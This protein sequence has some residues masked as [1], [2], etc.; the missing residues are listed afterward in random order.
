MDVRFL[1]DNPERDYPKV[2]AV[3]GLKLRKTI[4][5]ADYPSGMSQGYMVEGPITRDGITFDV[6]AAV[7]TPAC[8]MG[9]ILS[10][11]ADA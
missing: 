2:E 4:G 3:T 10:Q 5:V 11:G 6:E 7:R 1:T 9:R 8:R